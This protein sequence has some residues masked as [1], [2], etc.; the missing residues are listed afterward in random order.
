MKT[1]C[2]R[3]SRIFARCIMDESGKVY[4]STAV[5]KKEGLSFHNG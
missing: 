1:Y 3:S 5:Y 4:V 2:G